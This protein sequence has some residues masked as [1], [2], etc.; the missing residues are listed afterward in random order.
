MEYKSKPYESIYKDSDWMT[1]SNR[2]LL[3]ATFFKDSPIRIEWDFHGTQR[4]DNE[5]YLCFGPWAGPERCPTNIIH[6][7]A[8]LVEIDDARIL[9]YGWGLTTPTQY[10]PGR[11]SHIASVP[12][13]CQPT[14]RETRVITLAWQV[15]NMLG[16][17]ETPRQALGSLTFMPDWC[18]VPASRKET[19]KDYDDSRFE[20]LE[21]YM[22]KCMEEK[23]TVSFFM[24]EWKRKNELLRAAQCLI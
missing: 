23:Y 14:L 8:H 7:M 20:Y 22:I 2:R 9:Q 16:L 10:I 11:Y 3:E 24:S 1:D 6:E 21:S 12:M 13:T 19:I 15:Q 17:M 4:I 18:N 5:K